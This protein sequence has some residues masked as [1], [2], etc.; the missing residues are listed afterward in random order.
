MKLSTK[1]GSLVLAIV[2][3][4]VCDGCN[5][6]K[7]AGGPGASGAATNAASAQPSLEDLLPKQAQP[8]LPTIK[9]WVGAEELV[10]E[11]ALTGEQQMA[12]MM[13]RTNM[14]ENTAMIFVHPA[15]RQAGYWMKHCY[16]PLSIAYMDTD[17]VI[18]E[19]HDLQPHD[20]NSVVSVSTNVR[21]ALET[22]QG[23]FQRHN[24]ST[25]AV[26]RTERGSL[27]ETFLR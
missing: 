10:T 12:G 8:K 15:P 6:P 2:A 9:I 1:T 5:K 16:V 11:V 24:V 18:L 19:I 25:G 21:F 20:T 13:W 22:P 27:R 14:P 3:V 26:V 23:W 7:P 17:G 4:A